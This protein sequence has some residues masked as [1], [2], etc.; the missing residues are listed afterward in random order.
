MTTIAYQDVGLVVPLHPLEVSGQVFI[1][2]PDRDN[3]TTDVP[4][5]IFSDYSD[6]D[7]VDV[8]SSTSRSSRQIRMRIRALKLYGRIVD[9]VKH[10]DLYDQ[11]TTYTDTFE[12]FLP[13]ALFTNNEYATSDMG[14]DF[15]GRYSFWTFPSVA[16]SSEHEMGITIQASTAYVGIGTVNP[17]NQLEIS[18]YETQ[19][20]TVDSYDGR[21]SVGIRDVVNFVPRIQFYTQEKKWGVGLA[22]TSDLTDGRRDWQIGIESSGASDKEVGDLFVIRTSMESTE[23][24]AMTIDEKSVAF[25]GGITDGVAFNI[26]SDQG[27]GN[28]GVLQIAS[29]AVPE[30]DF[31]RIGSSNTSDPLN[32]LIY[33]GSA[34]GSTTITTYSQNYVDSGGS[35][36]HAG[37]IV[38]NASSASASAA[39]IEP[40]F[41]FTADESPVLTINIDGYLGI[42]T[43]YPESLIQIGEKTGWL[44][45][46]TVGY[47]DSSYDTPD[48]ITVIHPFEAARPADNTRIPSMIFAKGNNNKLVKASVDLYYPP[49]S[50]AAAGTHNGSGLSISVE[51]NTAGG[52]MIASF[53]RD[54]NN[55]DGQV[56]IWG[57]LDV[58]GVVSS[59]SDRTLKENIVPLHDNLQRIQEINP[60]YFNFKGKT[61]THV[62]LI[63]QEVREVLPDA[64]TERNG[65][66]RLDYNAIVASL[67]GAV[68]EL[69]EKVKLL[70]KNSV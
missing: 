9:V 3:A 20:A 69:S 34:S 57:N 58:S 2:E 13:N 25:G 41:S 43:E 28:S 48:A 10:N 53:Y 36:Y 60:I 45:D 12:S 55:T 65:T 67:V 16:A 33:G 17:R 21:G 66:L 46:P 27:S 38:F 5:E 1:Q 7:S 14:V 39:T 63:A 6:I 62:G 64:V 44:L 23:T 4:F 37:K 50:N 22:G 32:P 40:K 18:N 8:S 51:N 11:R 52:S 56:D 47:F 19:E 31:T 54:T 24:V 15:L 70:E 42:H 30:F 35:D 26:G 61:D 59:S 68:K 49:G 29:A